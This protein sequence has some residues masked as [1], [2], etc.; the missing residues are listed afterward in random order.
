MKLIGVDIGGTKCAVCIGE[1]VEEGV[2]VIYR[3]EPHRTETVSPNRMLQLLCQ[4]IRCCMDY[5]GKEAVGGIG[6]SCGGPLDSE[7]GTIL[8]PPNLPGWDNIQI[9]EILKKETG[10]NAWLCNDAN[11][12][13]LAEWKMGAGK[14]CNNLV[15]MTFGTGLGAGL[16]LD[17]RLYTG[18]SNMAGE[19]GHIRLAEFGPSGYGKMGS[20]EGFC[21]GGGISQ[22]AKTRVLEKIQQGER[23]AFCPNMESLEH[24]TAEAVGNAAEQGDPLALEIF[25]QVGTQLGRGLSIIID[26]LNPE[27]IIIGSI[28]SRRRKEIW[29]AAQKIIEQETLPAANLHCE[30]LPSGLDEAVGDIASLMVAAYQIECRN[31]PPLPVMKRREN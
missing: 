28:F 14:G 13:A 4:D 25:R 7:S 17:G 18:A 16:I 12:C 23:P 5:A 21:S 8:S 27:R 31:R 3:C 2:R 20:F 1:A 9:T 26:L 19:L 6:I 10:L 29:P 11:A 22:L 24:L 30:I 15:F